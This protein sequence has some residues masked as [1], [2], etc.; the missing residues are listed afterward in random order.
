MRNNLTVVMALLFGSLLA[1]VIEYMV[2]PTAMA[3]A[4]LPWTPSLSQ[5][6]VSQLNVPSI[7]ESNNGQFQVP[8]HSRPY[9]DC[10]TASA[11][12]LPWEVGRVMTVTQGNNNTFSHTGLAAWAFDFGNG[13][14]GDRIVAS[15]GGTVTLVE[16][17]NTQSGCQTWGTD[18]SGKKV[19]QAW[20][21]SNYVVIAHGTDAE[22]YL[23]IVTNSASKYGIRP[24]VVVLKGQPIGEVGQ[25]GYATGPH[26]HFQREQRGTS[27]WT[28]SMPVAFSDSNVCMQN[29]D[30]IPTGSKV[31]VSDNV[32]VGPPEV[33]F[34][35]DVP[36]GIQGVPA[37]LEI[38]PMGAAYDFGGP[39]YTQTVRPDSQ[40]NYT[41]ILNSLT[42]GQYDVLV[43]PRTWYRML[44]TG[45]VLSNGLNILD[46]SR[47][48]ARSCVGDID[49][50]NIIDS[51]DLAILISDFQ[52][53]VLKPNSRSDLDGDNLVDSSDVGLLINCF[54]MS[55]IGAGGPMPAIPP[56]PTW[57]SSPSKL[58]KSPTSSPGLLTLVPGPGRMPKTVRNTY[59]VGDTISITI[60]YDTGG[61]SVA[62]IKGLVY[63]DPGVL[64][65]L[66]NRKEPNGLSSTGVYTDV[67]SLIIESHNNPGDIP[68]TGTGN[69]ITLAFQAIRST[70]ATTVTLKL[71]AGSSWN[72]KI[73]EH[74]T[75]LNVLGNVVDTSFS[76]TGSPA[77][78]AR[79]G[80]ILSP[81]ASGYLNST[82]SR[83]DLVGDDS[84]A[85]L[86]K[87]SLEAYYDNAWHSVGRTDG[88]MNSSFNPGVGANAIVRAVVP[89]T[90][91]Q[92]LIGGDFTQ[93]SGTDRGGL[94]R[95]NK[96]GT[97]DS[98]FQATVTGGVESLVLLPDG[99][100]LVGGIFTSVNGVQQG[101][102]AK[103]NSDGTL[104]TSFNPGSGANSSVWS[105]AVDPNGMIIIGGD[106]TTVGGIARNHIARLNPNGSLDLGFNPG[107]GANGRIYAVALQN[108]DKI[109]AAGG[110]TTFGGTPQNNIT[111]L[112]VDGT[113]DGSFNIGTGPNNSVYSM[114]VQP[115]GKV[116]I[117]GDFAVVNGISNNHIA[118]LNANGTVDASF[119]QY[120]DYFVF[121]IARQWDG[122]ILIGGQFTT[123]N[124]RYRNHI[125]RLFPDGGLDITFDPGT[126]A[127][128]TIAAIATLNDGNVLLGGDFT[129]VN[130]ETYYR[131]ARIDPDGGVKWKMYWDTTGVTDQII[132]LRAFVGDNATNGFQ[133]FANNIT[134][135]RTPPTRV[136]PS[137][138]PAMA[139]PG[140]VVRISVQSQDNLAGVDHTDVYVNSAPGTA[141]NAWNLIGSVTGSSGSI[142]WDTT[143]YSQGI[144]QLSFATY[145]KAGNA[146][147]WVYGSQPTITFPLA[148]NFLFLPFIRK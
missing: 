120:S 7:A 125:A 101:S 9:A 28:Q 52:M 8:N 70:P 40:G 24:G 75:A 145:D 123:V 126:G 10:L 140:Q 51:S 105:I 11:Y 21:P 61:R 119:G 55:K 84:I 113:L 50:D 6:S 41:T 23:H 46:W 16:E 32:P 106:F 78:P 64:K 44:Q 27:Y 49:G 69:L 95:L 114:L 68:V 66:S 38:R 96:D 128:G 102:I 17:K 76:I 110:F 116:L 62:G 142:Q 29:A 65:P 127:N 143:G 74:G 129:Q 131:V 133:V 108:P 31:Y 12:K 112:N 146:N 136:S 122:K 2:Q 5:L 72:S 104:D 80:A 81:A 1:F 137:I 134:L 124:G 54:S 147:D 97:L 88:S 37:T 14:Q 90:N 73:V 45:V 92:I 19:C 60:S 85:G 67:H 26:I 141:H 20:Y 82:L 34:R 86:Q 35:L 121:A 103:L 109:L 71:D 57:N 79:T 117:G 77:R 13:R 59:Q 130:G 91:G 43:K 115:D 83:I 3:T 89:L 58:A 138:S 30:G 47:D 107:S 98:G 111:R 36:F 56:P 25:V 53:G 100:I 132:N 144:Y 139:R 22:A 148:D 87:I 15:Q 63:Y 39:V 118:R 94:A 4:S 18:A 33:R 135:D 42:P 48:L 93:Y 99:K